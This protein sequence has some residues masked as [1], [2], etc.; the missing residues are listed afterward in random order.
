[1]RGLMSRRLQGLVRQRGLLP[2]MAT[3]H[4]QG[5]KGFAAW[6]AFTGGALAVMVWRRACRDGA[7]ARAQL[8]T[9]LA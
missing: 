7:A 6:A 5:G 8:G 4:A 1:M 3:A 2:G 9:A